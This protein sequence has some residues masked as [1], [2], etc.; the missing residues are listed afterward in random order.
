MAQENEKV[1]KNLEQEKIR[2]IT[3]S[4]ETNFELKNTLNKL[5]S[6]EENL[7]YTQ[8]Q[9]EDFKLANHKYQN[10]LE[11]YE[12]QIDSLRIDNSNITGSLQ[13]EKLNKNESEKN[14][15]RLQMV[16]GDREREIN[17]LIAELE[18]SKRNGNKLSDEIFVIESE[19]QK[20][21]NHIFILTEQNEKVNFLI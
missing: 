10:T 19:S 21:K 12:A 6:R 17:R 5:K 3:R 20:L 18:D 16:V 13:K 8:R 2:L 1:I 7:S 14:G 4:D 11:D 15:E 9:L